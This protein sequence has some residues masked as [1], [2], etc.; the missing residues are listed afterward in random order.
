MEDFQE[1]KGKYSF[2]K[3]THSNVCNLKNVISPLLLVA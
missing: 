1:G 2:K 3:L